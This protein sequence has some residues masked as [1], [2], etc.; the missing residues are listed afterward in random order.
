VSIAFFFSNSF[1]FLTNS[2]GDGNS[3]SD[4]W[5][6]ALTAGFDCSFVSGNSRPIGSRD[7]SCQR[8]QKHGKK[9]FHATTL[10]EAI[11]DY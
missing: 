3:L 9:L 4:G 11:F 5:V 10:L 7:P 2:A 6:V 1:I 8:Q